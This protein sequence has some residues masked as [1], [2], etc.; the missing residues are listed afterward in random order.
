MVERMRDAL[1]FSLKRELEAMALYEAA[2]ARVR[3]GGARAVLEFL[4]AEE[5]RHLDEMRGRFARGSRGEP[6]VKEA[7][8]ELRRAA[9]R[10]A[11]E[12]LE[13]ILTRGPLEALPVLRAALQEE[14]R[15]EE[16]YKLNASTAPDV[17]VRAFYRGLVEE[18]KEHVKTIKAALRLVQKGI[19]DPRHL[20]PRR[21][22]GEAER[23]GGTN[24]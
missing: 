22:R 19:V 17:E 18:E 20:R 6:E 13:G 3:D 10:N 15:S 9:E 7:L 5:R 8:D 24:R 11:S 14:K 16:L 21:R 12:K 1:R 23:E 4:A 2:L